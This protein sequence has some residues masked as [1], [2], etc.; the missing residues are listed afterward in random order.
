MAITPALRAG[1]AEA[2]AAVRAM[3]ASA[4][5]PPP[6][7]DARR[8]SGCSLGDRCQ[9]EALRRLADAGPA[10]RDDLFDPPDEP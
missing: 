10:A 8:C 7:T 6:T 3:L 2:T 1:V 9:P 5:L 4:H